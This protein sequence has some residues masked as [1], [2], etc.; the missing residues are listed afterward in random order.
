[1]DMV[2]DGCAFTENII[3]VQGDQLAAAWRLTEEGLVDNGK[4]GPS[5]Q[6]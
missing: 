1:M 3:L 4:A 2:I 6:I 5:G